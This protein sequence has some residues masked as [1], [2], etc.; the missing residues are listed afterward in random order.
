MKAIIVIL[1]VIAFATLI[2]Y[3]VSHDKEDK[4]NETDRRR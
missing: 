1:V 3:C 4:D 2:L